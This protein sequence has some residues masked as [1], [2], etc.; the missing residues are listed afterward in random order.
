MTTPVIE[1][2]KSI[3]YECKQSKYPQVEKLPFRSLVLGR[4]GAGKGVLLQ[5]L[6][7]DI[8]KDVFARIYLM[9]ASIHV[10]HTWEPVKQIYKRT[11]NTI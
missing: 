5:R 2:Y 9:S 8:Y 10:D 11:Y 7:L 4:S 1:P 3:T 6:I